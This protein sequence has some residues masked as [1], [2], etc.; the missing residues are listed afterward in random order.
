MIKEA[1]LHASLPVKVVILIL[2]SSSFVLWA[3]IIY[4]LI[5]F[6]KMEKRNSEFVD[7]IWSRGN[8]RDFL[9]LS[10]GRC[11]EFSPSPIAKLCSEVGVAISGKKKISRFLEQQVRNICSEISRFQFIYATIGSSAPFVGLFGTVWGIMHS[12]R[13]IAKMGRAGLE[14]VAPG[15]AEALF[16]TALGLFVAIPAVIAYNF[17]QNKIKRLSA[18]LET[19]AAEIEREIE[20]DEILY[21]QSASRN[22]RLESEELT[23]QNDLMEL[24]E[25]I[26][27]KL[28]RKAD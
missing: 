11:D 17:F 22:I 20:Q 28:K 25:R 13:D 9:T 1:V 16:T 14:V 7:F 5:L 23:E 12:F 24:S 4:N 18:E 2:F 3:L 8:I 21:S 26:K 27:K 15:I 19:F 10:Y 6:A